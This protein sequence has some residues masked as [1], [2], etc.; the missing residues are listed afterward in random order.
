MTQLQLPAPS[1]KQK[2]F[3]RDTH[4]YVAYGGA[5]GGGKSWAVR[6]KALLLCLRH[7]NIRIL[8]LRKTYRELM[9]N[10]IEPLLALIPQGIARY[11]KTDKV[12]RFQ[13]G[14]A[15]WFG[16]CSCDRDLDQYQGAEYDVIFF[17]EATQFQEDWIRK[18]NLA[19]R[20]PN[21]LPKRTYYT[22]NPGGVSHSYFKRLFIDRRYQEGEIPENYSFIPALVTDNHALMRQQ[23]QYIKE[24]EALP[25]K[26]RKAWLEGS[27]DITEGQF[28]EEFRD[29]P[30]HY[31][32]RQYT[33]V[34]DPF[35]VPKSWKRYRSFDWGYNKPFSCGWWAVDS[36]GVV[37]RILELY[38]CTGS[39]N[40]G[41]RW[42]PQQVFSEIAKIEREHPDLAG[43]KIIG[44]ADPAIWSAETGKSIADVGAENGVYFTRGDNKR[45]PGWMQMH[46]RLRFDKAGYPMLYVFRNCKD[47]IR[48]LPLLQYDKVKPEDLDTE[49]E[50]HIADET[51]YFCMA[52]PIPPR[53]FAG[54]DP[55]Q[56]SLL[57]LCLDME[58]EEL[59]TKRK[60]PKMEIWR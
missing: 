30:A 27:W 7:P 33:H 37:Y 22:M 26:L 4:R 47:F 42:T 51:R 55:F 11:H 10:H 54:E 34:I 18:I 24:L 53:R 35:P 21:G 46:Y 32:D 12:L 8:I 16:Y 25:P 17:D 3:L 52:R 1:G 56:S 31:Q 15:I 50:D 5:R 36:D 41:V 48:T 49:G 57:H 20:Q 28:F 6:M 40:E 39:P 19:V 44:I 38:G 45:I 58:K 13:N 60:Q 23:P 59:S 9:N 2:L 29:N 14:A 43:E